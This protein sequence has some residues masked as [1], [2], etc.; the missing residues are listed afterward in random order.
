[1]K[2]DR[3][4]LAALLTLLAPAIATAQTVS[5][6]GVAG[7]VTPQWQVPTRLAKLFDGTVDIKGADF[8]IGFVRR[9]DLGGD[10]GVSYIRK[11]LKD[12]SLVEQLKPRCMSNGCFQSGT[13]YTTQGVALSG[14][15]IHKYLPFVTIKQRVQIGMNFAGGIGQFKGNLVTN[16]Y[17][18]NSTFDQ[19][20]NAQ[21][22]TQTLTISTQPAKD[23]V[24][25]STLPL[26]NIQAAVAVLVAPGLKVR[27]AGGLDFPGYNV[28][29]IT[30]VYLFGAK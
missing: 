29:N 19:R 21:N 5:S 25:I 26:A 1:M 8:S 27:F 30:A 7:S 6:W 3:R 10:W 11:P 28:F 15:E 4:P 23:L 18:V 22:G 16:D 12:G 20:T 14:V 13:S 2:M 9:R 24:S 17:Q